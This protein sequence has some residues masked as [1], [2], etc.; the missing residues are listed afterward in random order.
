VPRDGG[1]AVGRGR[2]QCRTRR[3]AAVEDLLEVENIRRLRAASW[4]GKSVPANG[5]IPIPIL[6]GSRGEPFSRWCK[7]RRARGDHCVTLNVRFAGEI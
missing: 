7:R 1:G 4:N 6:N 2:D 5:S 3:L